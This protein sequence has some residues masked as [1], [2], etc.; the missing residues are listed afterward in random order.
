M[1]EMLRENILLAVYPEGIQNASVRIINALSR[2]LLSRAELDS[3]MLV[4]WWP[5]VR[6]GGLFDLNNQAESFRKVKQYMVED[7]LYFSTVT[8]TREAAAD[9]MRGDHL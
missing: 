4:M 7:L 3:K 9:T 5:L 2:S 8:N 6:V 1:S